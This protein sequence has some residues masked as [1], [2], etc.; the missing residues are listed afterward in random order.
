MA[1]ARIGPVSA[2]AGL[3]S[4]PRGPGRVAAW[5]R[6]HWLWN[7]MKGPVSDQVARC[8][9]LKTPACQMLAQSD[10]VEAGLAGTYQ[11]F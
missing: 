9:A 5:V 8:L 11:W 6:G 2:Q 4:V 10:G 3:W 1:T 7:L